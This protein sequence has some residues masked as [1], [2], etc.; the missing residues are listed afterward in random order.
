MCRFV[1]YFGE[2]LTLD[3]LT[4]EPTHS[5]IHQSYKARE[6]R[7]PLNGDGFGIAWYAHD[8]SPEPAVFRSTT[9]AW[10]NTNLRQLARVTTSG[11]V[12]AHV[13]AASPLM[14]VTELNCHPFVHGR[15]MLMH[16]G[17]VPSFS[18]VRRQI[19]N[20]LSDEAFGSVRGTTDSEHLLAMLIDRLDG[21]DSIDNI[22]TALSRTLS[23]VAQLT[24]AAGIEPSPRLN[25][26]VS[27]GEGAVVSRVCEDG[28]AC[29]DSLYVHEGKKYVCELGSCRMV[30]PTEG[31]GAVIVASEPLSDDPG[32][33]MV[34]VN[35]LVVVRADRSVSFVAYA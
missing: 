12:F 30:E 28:A 2:A 35:H 27:N 22:A 16:N 6:R 20:G 24:R 8:I 10:S 11:C 14:A 13:R 29:C 15:V 32:W 31:H 34:P 23:D 25:V 21:D 4:T 1:M 7:E 19:I 3:R 17:Y 5:L 9:P 18:K 33:D 26:A